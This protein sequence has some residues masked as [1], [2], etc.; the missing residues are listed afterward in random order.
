MR[1]AKSL[2]RQHGMLFDFCIEISCGRKHALAD[3]H[4]LSGMRYRCPSFRVSVTLLTVSGG[5]CPQNRDAIDDTSA[6]T[7]SKRR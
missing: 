6:S 7:A 3:A 2:R 1:T 4:T 5:F